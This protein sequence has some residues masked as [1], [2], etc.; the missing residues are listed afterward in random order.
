MLGTPYRLF[1]VSDSIRFRQE[2]KSSRQTGGVMT[3]QK[4]M[5]L[6]R[7]E[8]HFLDLIERQERKDNPKAKKLK[9]SKKRRIK[10]RPCEK[11]VIKKII[12]DLD[13]P[14]GKSLYLLALARK[15]S[16]QLELNYLA[17]YK[18][19][20]AGDYENLIYVFERHF[21]KFASLYRTIDKKE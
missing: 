7:Q 2:N 21:G 13:G 9:A 14:D 1:D 5:R 16:C 17:I 19:M 3:T 4:Q 10:A 12:I 8:A 18:E 6:K 20:T 15:W 11:A